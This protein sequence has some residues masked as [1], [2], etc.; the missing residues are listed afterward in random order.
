MLACALVAAAIC[1]VCAGAS[2]LLIQG[3]GAGHG[4]GMSQEGA[5]GY[6][7]RGWTYPAILAHYYTG[8]ALGQTNPA[9]VVRVLLA[10]GRA[11]FTGAISAVATTTGTSSGAGAP[12]VTP[13]PRSCRPGAR[14]PSPRPPTA[15]SNFAD[16]A[17]RRSALPCRRR[18]RSAARRRS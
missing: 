1:P 17:D 11:T 5:L 6:A 3:A 4:V 2:T 12:P 14:T 13:V 9:R 15:S 10:D 16:P 8:T 18:S 7:K